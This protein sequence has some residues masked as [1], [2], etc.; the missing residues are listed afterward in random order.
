M[1]PAFVLSQD[2]TLKFNPGPPAPNRTFNKRPSQAAGPIVRA[3]KTFAS[4]RE[5]QSSPTNITPAFLQTSR[6]LG[7]RPRIPS[8]SSQSQTTPVPKPTPKRPP[9]EKPNCRTGPG[10][11]RHRPDPPHQRGRAYNPHPTPLSTRPACPN[12]L[13]RSSPVGMISAV[14]RWA[15]ADGENKDLRTPC[16][17]PPQQFFHLSLQ[18]RPN[19]RSSASICS[20]GGAPSSAR[21]GGAS[22]AGRYRQP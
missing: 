2:Q 3:S 7:R 19:P 5:L 16:P 17:D 4:M 6:R 20:G 22:S 18:S 13:R 10:I 8:L 11:L 12:P 21:S 14:G 9:L 15:S 1:P